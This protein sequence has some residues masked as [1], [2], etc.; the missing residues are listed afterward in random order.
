ME[1]GLPFLMAAFFLTFLG[2]ALYLWSLQERLNALRREL[3]QH[4]LEER[5]PE[6][7]ER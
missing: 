4:K 3:D 1:G 2:L 5:E 7:Q 6:Q